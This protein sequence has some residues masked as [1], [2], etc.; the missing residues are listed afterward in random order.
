MPAALR[1]IDE[2]RRKCAVYESP[3]YSA[4]YLDAD[5]RSVCNAVQASERAPPMPT[6]SGPSGPS[7]AGGT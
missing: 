3:Q 6:T 2:L 4:D 7:G 5:K 1:S